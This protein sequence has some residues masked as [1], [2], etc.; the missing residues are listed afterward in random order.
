M[1]TVA[2]MRLAPPASASNQSVTYSGGITID[3]ETKP[4]ALLL[5]TA[6]P[7]RKRHSR[8][9]FLSKD[10]F[11]VI[12]PI[13]LPSSSFSILSL[14]FPFLCL[15]LS[16]ITLRPS[17]SCSLSVLHQLLLSHTPSLPSRS[18]WGSRPCSRG[19]AARGMD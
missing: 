19:V 6:R 4:G 10:A 18:L 7:H 16:L 14:L 2:V 11:L 15:P 5:A 8:D 1:T 12:H 17:F 9:H 13:R 3:S